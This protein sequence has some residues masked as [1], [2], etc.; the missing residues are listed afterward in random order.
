ME[1]RT[2]TRPISALDVTALLSNVLVAA[3]DRALGIEDAHRTAEQLVKEL[4]V[5]LR[6]S[7]SIIESALWACN[8]LNERGAFVS[9]DGSTFKELAKRIADKEVFDDQYNYFRDKRR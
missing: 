4:N 8:M 3:Q 2:V 6:L 1:L 9:K 5:K 7:E